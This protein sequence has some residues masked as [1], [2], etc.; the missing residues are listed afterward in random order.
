M[1]PRSLGLRNEVGARRVAN[2]ASR[3][4]A[5]RHQRDAL[6]IVIVAAKLRVP[7]SG[8]SPRFLILISRGGRAHLKL[9]NDPDGLRCEAKKR[10]RVA[11]DAGRSAQIHDVWIRVAEPH[12][13][14]PVRALR[15]AVAARLESELLALHRAICRGA[16]Q[17]Q[18][19]VS[20][21]DA[22]AD[23]LLDAGEG[24]CVVPRP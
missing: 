5:E 12:P 3:L 19:D 2:L 15:F 24:R 4:V 18:R 17:D 16:S 11:V 13:V 7:V 10:L 21:E 8:K 6:L 1:D 9:S 20:T 23:F 22:L 14:E